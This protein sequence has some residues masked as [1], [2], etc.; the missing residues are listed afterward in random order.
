MLAIWVALVASSMIAPCGQAFALPRQGE[1][2]AS[3]AMPGAK[4]AAH[5]H[6]FTADEVRTLPSDS[7]YCVE[8]PS[9][10]PLKAKAT[11]TGTSAEFF[12]AIANDRSPFFA[13]AQA[14][15]IFTRTPA[16]PPRVCLKTSRLL[17]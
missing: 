14:A 12:A 5:E 13:S 8:I 4:H 11:S 16:A 3:Y 6:A 2:S 1:Q 15:R 9:S 17:I 10:I 7:S